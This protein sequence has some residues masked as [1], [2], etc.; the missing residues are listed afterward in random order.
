[1]RAAEEAA[2]AAGALHTEHLN[3][4][5]EFLGVASSLDREDEDENRAGK[6][7]RSASKPGMASIVLSRVDLPNIAPTAN[8]AF[9]T[10]N[11]SVFVG[12]A[13]AVDLVSLKPGACDER[14]LAVRPFSSFIP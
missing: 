2:A 13:V 8:P 12:P 14:K 5:G 3:R 10:A 6:R 11:S 1:M 4:P 7:R 9:A